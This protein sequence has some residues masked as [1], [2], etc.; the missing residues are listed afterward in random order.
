M[1]HVQTLYEVWK[2]FFTLIA[3]FTDMRRT[4]L[5][6]CVGEIYPRIQQPIATFAHRTKIIRTVANQV[7]GGERS[8]RVWVTLLLQQLVRSQYIKEHA[9]SS[10]ARLCGPRNLRGSR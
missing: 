7:F 9:H 3:F 2:E 4:S 10:F 8:Q 5:A 1:D 6:E